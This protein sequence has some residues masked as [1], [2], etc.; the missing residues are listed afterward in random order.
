LFFLYATKSTGNLYLK[1]NG[2]I[3][4]RKIKDNYVDLVAFE[5]PHRMFYMKF[6]E[7]EK[8][9]SAKLTLLYNFQN[10]A[11]GN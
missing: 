7:S 11:L 6:L 1:D 4:I 10:S 3:L 8:A 5:S 9:L 2:E